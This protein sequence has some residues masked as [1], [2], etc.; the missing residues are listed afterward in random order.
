[1]R[2]LLANQMESLKEVLVNYPMREED[3]KVLRWLAFRTRL[4]VG[5]WMMSD[6]IRGLIQGAKETQKGHF[7]PAVAVCRLLLDA[8]E[9]LMRTDKDSAI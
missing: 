6:F 9:S 7:A 3:A 8:T 1:M 5:K 4:T 2:H